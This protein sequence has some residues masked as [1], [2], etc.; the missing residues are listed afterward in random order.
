[1][2]GQSLE[3]DTGL[4]IIAAC[5]PYKKHSSTL[6]ANFEK[7]GLG[8]YMDMNETQ[9]LIRAPNKFF[10]F[11]C[12]FHISLIFCFFKGE[13]WRHS[14]ETF[15]VPSAAVAGEHVANHLGLWPTERRS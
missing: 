11:N 12:C 5:N 3:K 8:F 15:G 6:I 1:M 2:D 10:K 7:S 14:D 13:T 4:K 9:V